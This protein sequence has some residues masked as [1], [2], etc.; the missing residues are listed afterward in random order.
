MDQILK[1]KKSTL[2]NIANSIREK[3]GTTDLIPVL[4]LDD[5][6]D[7]LPVAGLFVVNELPEIGDE[8]CVYKL[9]TEEKANYYIYDNNAWINL[10]T[11]DIE[12]YEGNYVITPSTTEQV[13]RTANKKLTDDLTIEKIPYAEVSNSSNGKTVTIA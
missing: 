6:I 7:E 3:N 1:I 13:L 8:D 12:T 4:E 10:N 9:V 5:E 2:V 11:G